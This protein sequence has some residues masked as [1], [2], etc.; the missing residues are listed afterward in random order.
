[1][2]LNQV[3]QQRLTDP[4]NPTVET[5]WRELLDAIDAADLVTEP[6]REQWSLK[7]SHRH[8]NLGAQYKPRFNMKAG[9]IA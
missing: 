5:Q 4:Q 1:M 3:A 8:L 6:N 9:I 7:G 2:A